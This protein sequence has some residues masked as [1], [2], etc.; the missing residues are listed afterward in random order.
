MKGYCDGFEKL[1]RTPE[2]K[3]LAA[4]FREFI[5]E[6]TSPAVKD[7]F[8]RP[9][10]N[11]LVEEIKEAMAHGSTNGVPFARLS[12]EGKEEFLSFI[13]DWTDYLNRGLEVGI[14]DE[15]TCESIQCIIENAIA[16]KPSE[17]WIGQPESLTKK[18][19]AKSNGQPRLEKLTMTELE[20]ASQRLPKENTRSPAADRGKDKDIER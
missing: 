12:Q 7:A 3:T 15:K 18:G 10:V 14:G 6:V 17:H 2:Q 9:L 16:G 20:E 19:E 5:Y 4:S 8:Q 11:G 1:A 13:I